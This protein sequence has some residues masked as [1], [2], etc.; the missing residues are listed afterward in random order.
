VVTTVNFT[1]VGIFGQRGRSQRVV[2]TAH[3]ALGTGFT[4]LLN[5]HFE[6]LGR[7]FSL[8][9]LALTF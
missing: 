6:L 7:L 2:R 9:L 5:S 4:V 1:G 3:A 8:N